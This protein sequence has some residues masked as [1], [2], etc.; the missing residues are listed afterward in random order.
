AEFLDGRQSLAADF[1]DDPGKCGYRGCG[2]H[3]AKYPKEVR[4]S[5]ELLNATLL[6]CWS[7]ALHDAENLIPY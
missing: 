2:G 3:P 6:N 7:A 4:P 5:L 1:K